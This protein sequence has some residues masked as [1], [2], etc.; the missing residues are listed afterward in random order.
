MQT[1]TRTARQTG[2][3]YLGLAITGALGFLTIRPILFADGDPAATLANLAEHDLLARAG[4]ALELGVVLTQALTAAWSYR[5]FRTTDPVAAAGIAAFGLVNAVAILGS[6]AALATA[7]DVA[8]Q[9]V[10]DAAAGVQT[11]Y[12]LSA[13]CWAAGNLFFGLWLMPMGLCVLRSGWMPQTLGR[14]LIAGGCGY[15]IA[16]FVTFLL[17]TADLATTLL[18]APASIAEFWMIGY[19]LIRG[20][21]QPATPHPADLPAQ[22]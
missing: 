19:L 21:R 6:T 17:P 8:Q 10:G 15:V 12:L 5:L 7:A 13:N 2:L 16:A 1:L 18:A 3:L 4:I 11:L 14:L 20:A 22:S 9:H